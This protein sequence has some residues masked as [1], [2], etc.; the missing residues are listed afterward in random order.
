MLQNRLAPFEPESNLRLTIERATPM[1]LSATNMKKEF[2]FEE[3]SKQGNF[4]KRAT[5][6]SVVA[7]L[8]QGTRKPET[9][10]DPNVVCRL[11]GVV[12]RQGLEL[13]HI[14]ANP[15]NALNDNRKGKSW[16]IFD[17]TPYKRKD[18]KTRWVSSSGESL[19]EKSHAAYV[20]GSPNPYIVEL[21]IRVADILDLKEIAQYSEMPCAKL[22]HNNYDHKNH[23]AIYLIYKCLDFIKGVDTFVWYRGQRAP[24]LRSYLKM[25]QM[26]E[27]GIPIV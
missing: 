25:L 10:S 22:F 14:S 23:P 1:M 27:F 17:I 15:K 12:D 4:F 16:G 21:I 3:D 26:M 2:G 19:T 13:W 20:R 11:F 9:M 8:Y 6:K 5:K 18:G 7:L 24:L